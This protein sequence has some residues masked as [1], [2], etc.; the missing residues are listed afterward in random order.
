MIGGGALNRAKI[1]EKTGLTQ[2]RAD[3]AADHTHRRYTDR[4]SDD[5]KVDANLKSLSGI[6]RDC[7]SGLLASPGF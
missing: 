1:G 4:Y 2:S 6:F 5:D 7:V 3:H